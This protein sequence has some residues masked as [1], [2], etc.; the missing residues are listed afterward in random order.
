MHPRRRAALTLGS[1]ADDEFS[2]VAA[3]QH[4]DE[5]GWR[6]LKAVGDV[7]AIANAPFEE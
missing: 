7:L 3:F 2:E 5:G 6:I 1:Y 4:A